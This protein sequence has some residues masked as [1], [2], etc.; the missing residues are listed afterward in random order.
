LDHT[1]APSIQLI[2]LNARVAADR[3]TIVIGV[4]ATSGCISFSSVAP[5]Y[6]SLSATA[7]ILNSSLLYCH[8]QSAA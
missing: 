5:I 7:I 1:A 2:A 8:R 3:C 6:A 4:L